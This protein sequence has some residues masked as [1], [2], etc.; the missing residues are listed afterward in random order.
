MLTRE[1]MLFLCVASFLCSC[2]DTPSRNVLAVTPEFPTHWTTAKSENVNAIG[3][4]VAVF[5]D[6]ELSRLVNQAW[7]TVRIPS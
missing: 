6:A 3:K 5:N 7:G 1:A 4:W 2:H